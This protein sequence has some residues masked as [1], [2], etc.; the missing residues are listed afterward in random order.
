MLMA[1]FA[2]ETAVMLQILDPTRASEKLQ[3]HLD[4]AQNLLKHGQS[5]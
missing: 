2:D 1:T 3:N 5:V 4:Q